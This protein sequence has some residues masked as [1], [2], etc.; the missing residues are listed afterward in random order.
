MEEMGGEEDLHESGFKR[1]P[2]IRLLQEHPPT[3]LTQSFPRA[4]D[5]W[6]PKIRRMHM[7]L[8]IRLLDVNGFRPRKFWLNWNTA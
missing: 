7:L 2:S 3:T 6:S 8:D 1:P 5:Q 4:A